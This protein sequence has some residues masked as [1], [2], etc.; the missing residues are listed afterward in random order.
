MRNILMLAFLPALAACSTTTPEQRLAATSATC[1]SYGFKQGTDA[2][3]N[4]VMQQENPVSYAAP[5]D[6]GAPLRKLGMEM[7]MGKPQQVCTYSTFG[8]T[9]TQTCQ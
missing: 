9:T 5:V 1:T 2:H 3:A 6:S 8:M 7:L 4:C